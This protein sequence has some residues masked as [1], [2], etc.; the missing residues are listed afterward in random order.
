MIDTIK[1]LYQITEIL[2]DMDAF[3]MVLPKHKYKLSSGHVMLFKIA[4]CY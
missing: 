4:T 2:N 3:I 1:T